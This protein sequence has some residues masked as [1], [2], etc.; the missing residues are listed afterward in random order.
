M[1]YI[2]GIEEVTSYK[3]RVKLDHDFNCGCNVNQ[4]WQPLLGDNWLQQC[5]WHNYLRLCNSP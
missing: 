3:W 2:L 5:Y 4:K 1:D